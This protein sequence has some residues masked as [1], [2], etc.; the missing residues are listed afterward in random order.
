VWG[1]EGARDYLLQ[2][3]ARL[4][5]LLLDVRGAKDL[6]PTD[7]LFYWLFQQA[8]DRI[9]A[10]LPELPA[11]AAGYTF[12]APVLKQREY[13]LDGL[14]LP[15]EDH[16]ELPALILEAQ[17]RA[18]EGFLLRLYAESARWLQQH[19]RIRHWRVVVFCPRR[20]L[21]FGDPEP[22]E[23][24]LERRVRWIELDPTRQPSDAPLLQ[25][26]LGLLMT[27]EARIANTVA[28]V[29]GQ[30]EGE[31][32]LEVIT[33]IMMTRFKGCSI[34]ELCAMTGLSLEDFRQSV[35]YREIY[36]SGEADGIAQ[37]R[38]EGE[39]EV[40]LRLLRRRC[41]TLS[42]SEEATIRA[43]PLERLETLADA[44]LDFGGADD[45]RN[46]LV[47]CS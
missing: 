24:F 39:A 27:P 9:L 33:A 4:C 13:R 21:G 37:G 6:M 2:V 7:A 40:I 38:V 47:Q 35:V 10:L 32:L 28:E 15:P 42:A 19:G 17:M 23:E 5:N 25:R 1:A 8:P 11:G 16:P 34:E 3:V 26:A 22:V 41:G 18:D 43:L 29:C 44:L 12:S 14:F 20:D 46:W 36:G 45:L 31:S 30:P